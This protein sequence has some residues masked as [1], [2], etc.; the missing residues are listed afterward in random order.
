MLFCVLN[1]IFLL[2]FS[3]EAAKGIFQRLT[4]LESYFRQPKHPLTV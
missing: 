2:D 3:F 1:D 4:F